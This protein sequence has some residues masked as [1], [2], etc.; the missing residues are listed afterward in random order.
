MTNAAV[1]VMV[2][3]LADDKTGGSVPAVEDLGYDR[4]QALPASLQVNALGNAPTVQGPAFEN[5]QDQEVERSA[6]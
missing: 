1:A 3:H 5:P 2:C 4:G 6:E